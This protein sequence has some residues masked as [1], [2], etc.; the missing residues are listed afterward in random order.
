LAADPA[1]EVVGTVRAALRRHG[2]YLAD[3]MFQ[4]DA[5]AARLG[6]AR[7]ELFA[8]LAIVSRISVRADH[9]RFGIGSE[10]LH[11]AEAAAWAAGAP[12]LVAVIDPLNRSRSLFER[13][14]WQ[15]YGTGV[16]TRGWRGELYQK[17]LHSPPAKSLP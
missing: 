3:A 15:H 2:P 7:D 12:V 11:H 8:R 14:G 17:T 1:G 5:L 10:L 4:W 16:S 9:R 6:F 13:F